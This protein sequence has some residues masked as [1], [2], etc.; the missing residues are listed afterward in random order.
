[1]GLTRGYFWVAHIIQYSQGV[2]MQL[3][4]RFK[5]CYNTQTWDDM[6]TN[7]DWTFKVSHRFRIITPFD[8]LE[9]DQ[10]N[11]INPIGDGYFELLGN[12]K[13]LL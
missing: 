7:E 3:K 2:I 10:R 8:I 9:E 13:E 6:L 5:W 11:R 1:M 4:P 12:C